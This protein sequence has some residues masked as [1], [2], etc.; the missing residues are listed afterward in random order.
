[1]QEI[2]FKRNCSRMKKINIVKGVEEEWN[3]HKMSF[4]ISYI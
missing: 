1:M 4:N 2:G 3:Q